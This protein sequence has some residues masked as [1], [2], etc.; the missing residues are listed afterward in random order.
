MAS[1]LSQTAFE[2][3]KNELY[4]T[5]SFAS[6]GNPLDPIFKL[7][8]AVLQFLDHSN[9]D[10]ALYEKSQLREIMQACLE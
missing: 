8:K 5:N 10:F 1:N 7:N 9:T 4:K 2:L 6:E 3:L